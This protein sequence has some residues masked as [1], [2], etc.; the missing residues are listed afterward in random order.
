MILNHLLDNALKFTHKGEVAIKVSAICGADRE[1]FLS[2]Q[3]KDTGKGIP[4]SSLSGLGN[5]FYS[6]RENGCG[7]G[8]GVAISD[9]LARLFKNGRLKISSEANKGSSFTF[10]GLFREAD[11]ASPHQ[12]NHLHKSIVCVDDNLNV[13]T[14]IQSIMQRFTLSSVRGVASF[15]E[16]EKL[17]FQLEDEGQLP[18][19]MLLDYT[20]PGPN[21]GVQLF[22]TD[23]A[24]KI[25]EN[26]RTKAVN[27]IVM[28]SPEQR[29]SLLLPHVDGY[30][31]KP[32]RCK[33]L[34]NILRKFGS[35]RDTSP[36]HSDRLGSSDSDHMLSASSDDRISARDAFLAADGDAS[37]LH[38]LV[39]EDNLLNQEV[40]KRIVQSVGFTTK[41]TQ[42]GEECV[43]EFKKGNYDL[44][45]MDCL[46]PVLSG[47]EATIQIRKWEQMNGL[48]HTPIIA[49]TATDSPG[50]R[51]HCLSV[52]MDDYLIKPVKKSVLEKL[53]KD[54][55]S[56]RQKMVENKPQPVTESGLHLLLVED[57]PINAKI[58]TRLLEKYHWKVDLATDGKQALD[59]VMSNY[60]KYSV[61]LMDIH[62][63]IMDGLTC[64]TLIRQFEKDQMLS[65][66]PI[67]ALTADT[68]SSHKNQCLKAGC[69]EYMNK[70]IDYPLLVALLERYNKRNLSAFPEGDK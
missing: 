47:F 65:A 40:V 70:P 55:L 59:F 26:P 68:M 46:M 44:I 50:T 10:S 29:K 24:R 62:L 37:K 54:Y 2:V 28:V 34:L 43:E 14:A 58:A 69:T 30:L 7:S 48:K 64:T 20:M 31:T 41:I 61:V 67:I 32:I 39:A 51:S 63:P 11:A 45:L 36:S 15:Q 35:N 23:L 42:N 18:D 17:I 27:I 8:L 6:L 22:C 38:I 5:P 19:A 60:Y 66:K 21:G 3:V 13:V 12:E 52:G 49:L 53:L 33:Q 56:K 25:K 9:R 4:K 57:N 1:V 16:A